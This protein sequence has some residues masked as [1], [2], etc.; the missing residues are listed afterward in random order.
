M[1]WVLGTP[2]NWLDYDPAKI[3]F[4]GMALDAIDITLMAGIQLAGICVFRDVSAG[5]AFI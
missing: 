5:E 1:S 2:L 4:I 3:M